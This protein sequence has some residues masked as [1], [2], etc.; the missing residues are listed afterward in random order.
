M[1]AGSD[2]SEK[3]G[4][5]RPWNEQDLN[6]TANRGGV[7]VEREAG[8]LTVDPFGKSASRRLE[9]RCDPP[10]NNEHDH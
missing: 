8:R 2:L 10:M 1:Q 9:R 4:G 3:L 5:D 7:R 6:G